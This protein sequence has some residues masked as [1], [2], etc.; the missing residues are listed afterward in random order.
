MRVSVRASPLLSSIL[1]TCLGCDGLCIF[2]SFLV[3]R[4]LCLGSSLVCFRMVRVS[5]REGAA[6]VYFSFMRVWFRK[7]FLFVWGPL[8]LF[9]LSSLLRWWCQLPTFPSTC[10]FPFLQTFCFF[11]D[12]A[13]QFFCLFRSS[14]WACLD[15]CICLCKN[16]FTLHYFYLHVEKI[17]CLPI[18]CLYVCTYVCTHMYVS[19]FLYLCF[20]KYMCL[21]IN[22][23]SSVSVIEVGPRYQP[24]NFPFF[25]LKHFVVVSPPFFP[26]EFFS[27][28]VF[29]YFEWFPCPIMFLNSSLFLSPF[30][31]LSWSSIIVAISQSIDW[32]MS[33][34][35]RWFSKSAAFGLQTLHLWFWRNNSICKIKLSMLK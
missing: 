9:F 16:N 13:V 34:I 27:F 1:D 5:Y 2:I 21:Y 23:S 10:N 18:M 19:E 28:F 29:F 24:I 6:Q 32:G 35:C 3:F 22:A 14:L 33:N 30:F 4:S 15:V 8:F 25:Q 17:P 26:L 20:W 31:R 12:L 7:A 11:L